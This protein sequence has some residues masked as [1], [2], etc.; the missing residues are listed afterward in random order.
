MKSTFR[1]SIA[2]F[3]LG[4]GVL[5]VLLPPSLTAEES[6]APDE[7]DERVQEEIVVTGSRIARSP[8]EQLLPTLTLD[9][10]YLDLRGSYNLGEALNE[11][12]VF[13]SSGITDTDFNQADVDVGLTFVDLFGL[14]SQRTLTLIDGMRVVSSASPK[15]NRTVGD[16]G[17]QVDVGGIPTALI[18]RVDTITIGGAPI[19]GADAIAGTVNIVLKDDF[20]GIEFDVQG[21][22]TDESDADN[23][24]A[25]VVFGH[26]LAEGRGNIAVAVEYAERSGLLQNARPGSADIQ[27]NHPWLAT[28]PIGFFTADPPLPFSTFQKDVAFTGVSQYGTPAVDLLGFGLP[29]FFGD[30]PVGFLESG[31]EHLM[32]DANGE[33]VPVPLGTGNGTFLYAQNQ[34]DFPGLF[35][36]TD[37]NSMLNDSERTNLMTLAHYDINENLRV[38]A[39]L[40]FSQ[41]DA[42][43]PTGV[44]YVTFPGLDISIDNPFLNPD[45]RNTI[46]SGV[47]AGSAALVGFPFPFTL[48][49][50][51]FKL[52]RAMTD[53]S[54]GGVQAEGDN[55]SAV[56]GLEG[57]ILLG[58]REL[59]WDLSFS[60]GRASSTNESLAVNASRFALA[61]N[62][63]MIHPGADGEASL[64]DRI[65]TDSSTF[66]DPRSMNFNAAAG[67]WVNSDNT[68]QIVCRARV[69]AAAGGAGNSAADISGC[70]P[71]NP[72]GQQNS[73][74]V[75]AY[76]AALSTID[77]Q[78]DQQFLQGNI[79]GSL[80]ELPAGEVQ[81][82]LGFEYRIEESSFELDPLTKAG[83]L[84]AA[85]AG[86]SD[87]S[88]DFD[89]TEAYA[90]VV[91]P[92]LSNDVLHALNFEA[93]FRIIDNDVA[94]SDNV[95]TAGLRA[96]IAGGFRLR[97][98]LTESVRAPSIAELFSGQ[99]PLFTSV[100]DPCANSQIGRGSNPATRAANCARAVMDAGLAA[101]EAEAQ[102]FLTSYIG[103]IGGIA[104]TIG[105]NPDLENERAESWTVGIAWE[106]TFMNDFVLAV[107]WQ[108]ISLSSPIN[109]L[110]ASGIMA[111]CYDGSDYPGGATC[112]FFTRDPASFELSSYRAGFV[113]TGLLD[114]SAI[115]TTAAY[116][117]ELGNL[118]R[119]DLQATLF[120]L[121]RYDTSSNN[122]DVSDVVELTGAEEYRG[123]FR[124]HYRIRNLG[125]F[126]VAN[127]VDSAYL[128]PGARDGGVGFFEFNRTDETLMHNLT[129]SY[130]FG[131]R[132]SVRLIVNNLTEEAQPS[133]LSQFGNVEARL[134]RSYVLGL[135]V[136]L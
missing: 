80:L 125:I 39:R 54:G 107:D 113:N 68:Q 93:A 127:W 35:R 96:E 64:G 67:A 53:I 16:S 75:A 34:P 28:N 87:V 119:L 110:N 109:N 61:T 134:G 95:W 97:G 45:A 6:D 108:D 63:V 11:M 1:S 43:Q 22:Q 81:F 48:L 33:L 102:A 8:T 106:P 123:Q 41:L 4:L 131:E 32:F 85:N 135:N 116:G 98:N 72:F 112:G 31:G 5:A 132:Y 89:S 78:V 44:P 124:A 129:L 122:I 55:W 10:D 126:W 79:G 42:G 46:R 117:V 128:D 30:I 26:N 50:P 69:D 118:G 70:L 7:A 120:K 37:F 99:A 27:I 73:P 66:T 38:K 105:G 47:I 57:D 51:T 52:G 60:Q 25:R 104:G 115:T 56:L 77:T 71:Y 21:G 92:L 74:E 29:A 76:M 58:G 82:S 49:G 84:L 24:R 18:E 17:L 9:S 88:G 2:S 3:L 12:P 59:S 100:N 136:R 83:G 62:V 65:L 19:Y 114:F 14:G 20:E 91:V 111:S 103:R 121:T 94:G 133:E 130:D 15:P 86:S 40:S 13:S 101:S 23:L 36:E 90:E